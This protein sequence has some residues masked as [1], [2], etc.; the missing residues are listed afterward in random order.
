MRERIAGRRQHRAS[1]L[2]IGGTAIPEV[3]GQHAGRPHRA[4]SRGLDP[5]A[6]ANQLAGTTRTGLILDFSAGRGGC[7][8]EAIAGGNAC[9]PLPGSGG[10]G[11]GGTGGGGTGPGRRD[12]QGLPEGLEYVVA[13]NLCVIRVEVAGERAQTIV[14]GRPFEDPSGGS[15]ILPLQVARKRFGTKRCLERLGAEAC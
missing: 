1:S 6:R 11:P 8:G 13:D 12:V 10:T 5:R 4:D 3:A 15:V 14:V 9:L 2:S 7:L